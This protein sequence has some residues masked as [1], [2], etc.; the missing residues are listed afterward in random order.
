MSAPSDITSWD[1]VRLSA[2]I[3][4]R[5]VSCVEVMSDFLERIERLNPAVNAIVSL[6]DESELLA[7]ARRCDD[8]L[9]RGE[10]RGWMHGFPHAVKDLADVTG[11]PT[12][13]GSPLFAG[14]VASADAQHISRLR[15][16]GA[17]F[18]GKTNVPEAGLGSHSYN[19]VFGTT[20][21]PYD[22]SKS[23]GG[24]SGGAAAA[25]RL[26]LVPVADGSDLMG[27]LRNPAAFCNVI[28]MR[29]TPGLV[30]NAT[31][32]T[33]EM[34]CNG[35]MARNVQDT[36]FLLDT[37]AGYHPRYPQSASAHTDGFRAS[38]ARDFAEVRVGWL[39]DF[40]GYLPTEAGLLEL[41]EQALDSFTTI[42]C[43]VE[44]IM[45]RFDLD[46]LWH[47]WVTLRQWLVAGKWAPVYENPTA[48]NQLKPELVWEI[49]S[50][51]KLTGQDV[52]TASIQ[53]AEWYQQ[54]CTLFETFDYLVLPTAQV[55]PFDA[56]LSWPTE[57]AGQPMDTY[58]HWMEIVVAGSM[59]GCP[60]INVPAGF[61]AE[62][63]PMGLQIMA[64]RY[65][66]L[67]L[68]RVA[69]AY[70]QAT[71]WNLDDLPAAVSG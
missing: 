4:N 65:A 60:V 1:A 19:R 64:P 67:D 40:D 46:M 54:V 17:I 28:G 45:P 26:N 29:P 49:E 13:L 58:H 47:A 55:F 33:E 14:R 42:G 57:I 68:L 18:I 71:G 37:L 8:E 61:S 21:N 36:A 52:Y 34:S 35:P 63:L 44:R 38:L 66:E 30:P 25:L 23:A 70:E 50:G 39:G 27:S 5:D 53:R 12:T 41:C 2:A 59:S 32:F 56:E 22:P 15:A 69:H 51:R 10:Y 48:K 16:A 20:L 3:K 43:R 6:R 9:G 11:L 62:G 7:E 24:S 31:S